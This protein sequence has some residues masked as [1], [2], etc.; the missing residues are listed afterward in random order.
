MTSR[1]LEASFDPFRELS[2][3]L[4]E[5]A[6]QDVNER[7]HVV[8]HV[9]VVRMCWGVQGPGDVTRLLFIVA[10]VVVHA[11]EWDTDP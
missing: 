10:G 2:K 6:G 11:V 4:T 3:P 7:G 5:C 9:L 8:D 1:R